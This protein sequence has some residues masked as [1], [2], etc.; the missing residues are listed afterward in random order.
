MSATFDE[1]LRAV[2]DHPAHKPE[3]YWGGDFDAL[4]E[5]LGTTASLTVEYMTILFL[6]PHHLEPYSHDQVAQGIWFLMGES[7]PGNSAY[8]LLNGDVILDDRIGCVQAIPNF[9][10]EFVTPASRGAADTKNDPF[11][12]ACYMWWDIFPTYGGPNAGEPELH[13]A[14]LDA[15]SEML[16]LSSELCRLSALHGLNHWH[17]YHADRVETIV[18]SFLQQAP[19]LT[20]RVIEYAATARSGIGQ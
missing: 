20:P 1:W 7:S 6:A 15:M 5:S 9:F 4:W 18:D 14:C 13:V 11:H 19:R 16:S 8:A 2:F 17:L 12:V 3:W 10:K